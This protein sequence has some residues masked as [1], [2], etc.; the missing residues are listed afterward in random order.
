MIFPERMSLLKERCTSKNPQS[1]ILLTR[2]VDAKVNRTASVQ[3]EDAHQAAL[4]A[5]AEA[6]ASKI[7]ETYAVANTD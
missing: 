6:F 7:E 5:L 4:A 1:R 2:H 3:A